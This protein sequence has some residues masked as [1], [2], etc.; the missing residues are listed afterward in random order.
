MCVQWDCTNSSRFQVCNGVKQG[1]IISPVLFCIYIDDLLHR[2]QAANIGCFIGNIYAGCMAYADDLTL[3][4]PSAHS[5]R[6]MLQICSIVQKNIQSPLMLRK[7]NVCC[8]HPVEPLHIHSVLR[9]IL[10]I[11]L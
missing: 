7:A 1:A 8:L 10:M 6:I 4:A 9:F 2:L 11:M 3:L 5:M